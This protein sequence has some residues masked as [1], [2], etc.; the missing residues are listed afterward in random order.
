M[1]KIGDVTMIHDCLICKREVILLAKRNTTKPLP[2]KG[3]CLLSICD[4]CRE[5]YLV[6]QDGIALINPDNGAITVIKKPLFEALFNVPPPE[7]RIAHTEQAV[8]E[9][10]EEVRFKAVKNRIFNQSGEV[11]GKEC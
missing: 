11:N 2:E 7:D 8:L 1:A 3:S 9:K 5:E 6:K 4:D 10:I